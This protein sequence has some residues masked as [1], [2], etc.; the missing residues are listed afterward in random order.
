VLPMD[1]AIRGVEVFK[2]N[3][4]SKKGRTLIKVHVNV[5]CKNIHTVL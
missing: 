5:G 1:R 3:A 2:V 4:A